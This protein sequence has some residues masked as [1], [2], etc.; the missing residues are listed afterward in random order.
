MCK[1]VKSCYCVVGGAGNDNDDGAWLI[2]TIQLGDLL[3]LAH[4]V[5]MMMT[6]TG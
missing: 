3:I 2:V 1:L 4:Q 6:F 5:M